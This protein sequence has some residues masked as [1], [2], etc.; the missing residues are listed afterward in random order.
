MANIHLIVEG[1]E[2]D[3]AAEKL[4]AFFTES[5]ENVTVSRIQ[6]E[7]PEEVRR[8]IDPLTLIG[9][10]LSIPGAV[11]AVMDLVGRIS[12]RKK[13]QAL[14]DAAKQVTNQTNAQ[15]SLVMAEGPARQADQITPDQLL[16]MAEKF[17]PADHR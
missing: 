10:I 2:A 4:K 15:V 11:L 14:L 12:K 7:I 9:V 3:K 17:N 16:D 5:G 1:E 8:V 13:A 6:S